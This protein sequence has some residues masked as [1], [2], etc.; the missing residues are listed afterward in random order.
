MSY[1]HLHK[2]IHRDLK[3]ANILMDD[4]L[5]PKIADFGLSKILHTNKE[6]MSNNSFFQQ[7]GTPLYM[8]PEIYK[9]CEYSF[10]SD[11]YA[12]GVIV[13]EIVTSTEPFKNANA[14]TI[15]MKVINGERPE[16][17]ETVND[18]YRNLIERCWAQNPL[19]RPSFDEIVE[20]LKTDEGLI[21]ST[22]EKED[23]LNYVD[24]IDNY[25]TSFDSTR[26][27][28]YIDEFIKRKSK[29]FKR[30]KIVEESDEE[31]TDESEAIGSL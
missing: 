17:D 12:F 1:L 4:F 2:I 31:P 25:K 20:Y 19:D 5:F 14:F 10:A 7:K 23:F 30:F 26:C 3:P 6:S 9:D 16:I 21:T 11:V 15:M 27:I 24:F 28:I 22:I 29:T 18:S 8:S 13:Y